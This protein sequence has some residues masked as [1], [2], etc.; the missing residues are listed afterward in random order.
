M[1]LS[2]ALTA[3]Q[4]SQAPVTL[5]SLLD[6]PG[7]T[8]R[9]LEARVEDFDYEQHP[10]IRSP[11]VFLSLGRGDCDDFACLAD[12]VLRRRHLTTKLVHV[13]LVGQVAHAVCYVDESRAYLD[14]NKRRY[15]FKLTRCG[16]RLRDIAEEVADSF[17]ESWTSASEYTYDYETERKRF[18][19]T[20]VKI[21]PPEDDP[22]AER[23]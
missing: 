20:V 8:P 2:L 18:V 16:P 17:D 13:R 10:G 15:L 1:I 3:P 7:L 12:Y 22:D 9:R 21:Y 6:D 5:A 14:Y 4:P 23:N 11:E 19:R